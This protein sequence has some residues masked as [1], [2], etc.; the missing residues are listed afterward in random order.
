MPLVEAILTAEI[1]VKPSFRLGDVIEFNY[2]IL[3]DI[4][5]DINYFENIDC[6]K[7][8]KQL[9]FPLKATV[10]HNVQLNKKYTYLEITEDIEPQTCT[11]IIQVTSPIEKK[12]EKKFKVETLPSIIL[13]ILSCK[14]ISCES[15]SKIF[16]KDEDIYLSYISDI[17]NIINVGILTFPDKTTQQLTLPASIKAEQ[18]GTYELQVTASKEGY[19]TITKNVQ[20]G[21]IEK[22]AEIKSVSLC[23]VNNV[24]DDNENY[25]NCPQDCKSGQEDN[26]CDKVNDEVCDP[27]CDEDEDID[28]K[29]VEEIREEIKKEDIVMKELLEE[30]EK[31]IKKETPAKEKINPLIIIIPIIMF[32]VI[33]VYL[34]YVVKK[35]EKERNEIKKKS[36]KRKK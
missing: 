23:N 20:F 16:I 27:D 26:Y 7:M 12:F 11:A 9:L 1:E 2:T 18:I 28:C 32:I 6:P 3:S 35:H 13:E 19:K 29:V 10:D 4:K 24:C 5:Q 15:E 8:P 22:Q 17:H 31:R 36:R 34:E 25:K 14:D 21:V 33:F 30:V